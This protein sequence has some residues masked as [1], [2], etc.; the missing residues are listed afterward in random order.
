M[1]R[2]IVVM[3]LIFSLG[4]CECDGHTVQK[5]NQRRL[6]A[7]WLAPRES[8]YSRMRSKVSSDWLPSYIKAT[9]PVLEI[10][11][12]AGYF[13][14]RPR[15]KLISSESGLRRTWSL[16]H[17]MNYRDFCLE[18]GRKPS[19]GANWQALRI[20]LCT[21][22]RLSTCESCD[23]WSATPCISVN[24]TDVSKDRISSVSKSLRSRVFYVQ[25]Y[26]TWRPLNTVV[27]SNFSN[28]S[29]VTEN[30]INKK[31][32]IPWNMKFSL[33]GLWRASCLGDIYLY[34]G[35][36]CCLLLR[37]GIVSQAC[38]WMYHVLLLLCLLLH[39]AVP[40]FL[41]FFPDSIP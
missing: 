20:L 13:P 18:W 8:D 9:Q 22:W 5:L 36:K 40:K 19:S 35:G 37:G 32:L 23:I 17:L 25:S 11:K 21:C 7:D 30:G 14:N 41:L 26:M 29:N 2:R 3:K 12:M 34:F 1:G 15:I 16:C 31:L 4:H 38:R 6:T 28:L 39:F 33:Q 10:F 24:D 27:S